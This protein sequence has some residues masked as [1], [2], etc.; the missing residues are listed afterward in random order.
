[1]KKIILCLI[2]CSFWVLANISYCFA[3]ASSNVAER[4]ISEARLMEQSINR[5]IIRIRA[6]ENQYP[7]IRTEYVET[8]LTNLIDILGEL[9]NIQKWI[10]TLSRSR[11]ILDETLT[12][13]RVLNTE[14]QNKISGIQDERKKALE[15]W[16]HIYSPII[17]DIN[18]LTSRLIEIHSRHYLSRQAFSSTD[19]QG[20]EILIRLRN[21][22]RQLKNFTMNDYATITELQDFLRNTIELIRRDIWQLRAMRNL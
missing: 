20:V 14:L 9:D 21:N 16:I 1:M 18:M 11:H 4:K 12:Y 10:Y 8:T 2:L 3:S 5:F 17:A 22:N 7:E 13:I 15:R 19:K 6:L